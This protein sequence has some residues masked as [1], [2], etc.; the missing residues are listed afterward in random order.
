MN[1]AL[2]YILL[3]LAAAAAGFTVTYFVTKDSPRPSGT[4][5]KLAEDSKVEETRVRE[6]VEETPEA[7]VRVRESSVKESP[8][9][10]T[11]KVQAPKEEAPKEEVPAVKEPLVE[12]PIAAEP[13]FEIVLSAKKVEAVGDGLFKL[14]G[15]RTKGGSGA[16]VKYTLKDNEGHAYES[17]DGTFPEVQSN[18][19]GTYVLKAT[20]TTTGRTAQRSIS[21]FK[22]VKP[23]EKLSAEELT[24]LFNTGNGD[25]LEKVKHRFVAKPKVH[26]NHSDVTTLSAVF[27]RV[28][29]D[30]MTATVSQVTYDATGKISAITVSLQ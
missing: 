17:L 3:F 1:K 29:M 11:P 5:G 2:L 13:A 24:A 8:V 28:W 18:A 27:S 25:N 20:E 22:Y 16:A 10:E 7:E 12:K 23:V 6:P 14:S 9:T 21:G 4:A 26:C 30:G 15:I 19:K